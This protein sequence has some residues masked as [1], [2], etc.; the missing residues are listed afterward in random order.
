MKFELNNDGEIVIDLAELDFWISDGSPDD[1]HTP[2]GARLVIDD[3]GV[4]LN[5][6][7]V[8]AERLSQAL[9]SNQLAKRVDPDNYD[10][11]AAYF[12]Q[13]H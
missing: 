3:L 7:T 9:I 13:P 1:G 11:P 5:L 8:N 6:S 2:T 10:P 12:A 4:R